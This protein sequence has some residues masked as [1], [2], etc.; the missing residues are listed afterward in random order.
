LLTK[1]WDLVFFFNK[2]Q[3][4]FSISTT[5]ANPSATLAQTSIYPVPKAKLPV[6]DFVL[7]GPSMPDMRDYVIYGV[8]LLLD[9]HNFK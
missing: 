2:D 7:L 6:S 8:L 1:Y 9:G 3:S 5:T 4:N